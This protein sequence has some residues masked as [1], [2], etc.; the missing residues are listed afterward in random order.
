MYQHATLAKL[1]DLVPERTGP[2]LSLYAPIRPSG[3]QIYGQQQRL[4]DLRNR[5]Q[6]LIAEAE[7]EGPTA[8][9]LLE[10][11][12]E[13]DSLAADAPPT[14]QGLALFLAPGESQVL[15]S[16][17]AFEPEVSIHPVRFRVAPLLAAIP[18]F[19][20]VYVLALSV[21]QVR[22]LEVGPATVRRMILP[23]LPAS[24]TAALGELQFQS[25]LQGH[26]ASPRGLARQAPII[27]GHGDDDE[28]RWQTDLM[29]Y[30]RRV[31][32]ALGEIAAAHSP[33]VLATVEDHQPLFERANPDLEVLARITG[34]PDRTSDLDL[35]AR[36]RVLARDAWRR[37]DEASLTRL[38]EIPERDRVAT[39]AASVVTAAA[40]GRVAT[41]FAPTPR[42]IWGRYDATNAYAE[43]HQE[44]QPGD[45]DLL[46][47]AVHHTLALGGEVIAFAQTPGSATTSPLA[48]RLR[49]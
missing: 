9:R 40:Q 18:R 33:L 41:L 17:V 32:A 7:V 14:A 10:S 12:P 43:I 2:C 24:M 46:D 11:L 45:E 47:L 34:N 42:A 31:G 3:S 37:R 6:G 29:T 20:A 22:L 15:V 38:R 16:D 30:F 28:E 21:N 5:A 8:G 35:A 4:A 1:L 39:D 44:N 27:H 25:E 26:G 23:D 48:A 36:A 19:E 49:Y 13:L